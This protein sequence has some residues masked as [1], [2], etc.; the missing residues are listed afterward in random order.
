MPLSAFT[1]VSYVHQ[2][3]AAPL[4]LE[5]IYHPAMLLWKYQ[6]ISDVMQKI[7]GVSSA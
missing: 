4:A 3:Y 5:G 7:P 1:V 6:L 2:P